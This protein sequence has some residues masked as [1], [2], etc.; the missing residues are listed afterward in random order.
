MSESESSAAGLT[1]SGS[2]V[3]SLRLT[4]DDYSAYKSKF[5]ASGQSQSEFFREHVLTNTTKVVA[6]SKPNANLERM[7]FLFQKTSNNLNQLAHRANSENRAGVLSNETFAAISGQLEQ[8]NAWLNEQ[9][10]AAS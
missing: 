3:V 6:K 7:V 5:R 4:L 1:K 9:L 2:R 10:E 8:L